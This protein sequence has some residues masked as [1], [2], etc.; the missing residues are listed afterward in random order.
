MEEKMKELWQP[1]EVLNRIATFIDSNFES[2]GNDDL[3]SA[4]G[5]I[6][7]RSQELKQNSIRR[8]KSE[9]TVAAKRENMK[10]PKNEK[11]EARLKEDLNKKVFIQNNNN[12]ILIHISNKM[13]TIYV[14]N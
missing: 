14:S 7:A 9:A 11:L 13:S 12:F 5:N 2:I 1:A 10:T 4:L 6:K 3:S 8:A